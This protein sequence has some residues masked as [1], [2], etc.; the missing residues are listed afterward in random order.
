MLEDLL[1]PA[2]SAYQKLPASVQAA[3]GRA[4]RAL[5][6]RVRFGSRYQHFL[7]EANQRFDDAADQLEK[8][9]WQKV[10]PMLFEAFH[11]VPFYRQRYRDAGVRFEDVHSLADLSILPTISKADIQ[12]DPM[13]F[14]S[15]RFHKALVKMNSGG[16][17]GTPLA[18]Y[19]HKGISRAKERAYFDAFWAWS[20]YD[21]QRTPLAR[22]SGLKLADGSLTRYEPIRNTLYCSSYQLTVDGA[23]HI[24]EQIN[25]HGIRHLLGY[26]STIHQYAQL[27]EEHQL[28]P[29]EQVDAIYLSSEPLHDYMREQIARVLGGRL[30]NWYGHSERLV[31][32]PRCPPDDEYLV[33][34]LYGYAEVVAETGAPAGI[35]T[36]GRI[37]ATGMDSL[38]FP[39]IRYDTEDLAIVGAPS[40]QPGKRGWQVFRSIEGRS[41]EYVYDL[42]GKAIS[43]TAVVY[44]QHLEAFARIRRMQLHQHQLGEV[45]VWVVP[46]T[47]FSAQ[48]AREIQTKL[49]GVSP[50]KLSI[51]VV[52]KGSIEQ[53]ANGKF[54]YLVQHLSQ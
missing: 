18:F 49:S 20:G 44:G 2:L 40:E 28:P 45:E 53:A 24:T 5:P 29:P 38:A 13:Q 30:Q 22:L 12:A 11:H 41:I 33:F 7:A 14:V 15:E 19:L 37:V 26:C 46:A 34:P 9:Q 16:S 36:M 17:S 10:Q 6:E 52:E 27:L 3:V 54:K 23:R 50:G 31:L 48:D 21:E 25:Q 43:V 39:F 47:G 42:S 35:N 4:F 51:K 1:Y 32:A 8:L